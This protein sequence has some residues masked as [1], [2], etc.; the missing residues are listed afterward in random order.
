[1]TVAVA[2]DGAQAANF[3]TIPVELFIRPDI[4]F[5]DIVAE[6]VFERRVVAYLPFRQVV[7]DVVDLLRAQV[8][9]HHFGVGKEQRGDGVGNRPEV[10]QGGVVQGR[11]FFGGVH[12]MGLRAASAPRKT[13]L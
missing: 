4:S 5:G 11:V 9:Q 12:H 13:G 10:I 8:V 3:L 2:Q 7:G 1:M 6:H